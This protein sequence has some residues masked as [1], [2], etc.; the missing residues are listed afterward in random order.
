MRRPELKRGARAAVLAAA[1]ATAAAALAEPPLKVPIGPNGLPTTL[2]GEAITVAFAF[3]LPAILAGA[4]V[5]LRRLGGA[6]GLKGALAIATLAIMAAFA[7]AVLDQRPDL[8]PR[9]IG[10]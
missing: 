2:I 8:W 5:G 3:T 1:L 4:W 10:S 7:G 6:V 9:L